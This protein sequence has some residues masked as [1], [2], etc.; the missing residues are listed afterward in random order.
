MSNFTLD[1]I[2]AAAEKKYGSTDIEVGDITVHLLNP[3]RLPKAKRK[4]LLALQEQLEDE[5]ADQEE[6]LEKAVRLIAATEIEAD[7]LLE[8]VGDDLALLAE[9][10]ASYTEGQQAGEASA[11]QA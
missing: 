5:D 7:L 1:D 3:L 2:R 11:S 8:E 10:F 6:F 4:A 9:I